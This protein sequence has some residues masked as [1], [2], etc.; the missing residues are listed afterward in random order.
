MGEGC[1]VVC[2]RDEVHNI[3]IINNPPRRLSVCTN[4]PNCVSTKLLFL[5]LFCSPKFSRKL[6]YITHLSALGEHVHLDQIDIPPQ[7]KE[8]VANVEVCSHFQGTV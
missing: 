7:V 3:I 4:F 8:L 1:L 5:F 6:Y 2:V